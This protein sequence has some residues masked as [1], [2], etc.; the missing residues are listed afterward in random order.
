MVA[1]DALKRGGEEDLEADA[2]GVHIIESDVSVKRA[3][4]HSKR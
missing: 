1:D 4:K 2:T 3:C